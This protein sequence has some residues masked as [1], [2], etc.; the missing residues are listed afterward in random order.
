MTPHRL[1]A[2]WL[3]TFQSE[4]CADRLAEGRTELPDVVY[5]YIPRGHVD[6]GAPNSLRATQILALNDDMECNVTTMHDREMDI[7]DF[8]ALVQSRLKECLEIEVSEEELIK[9]SL[10][11]S[12]VRLS[13]FVQEY[14]IGWEWSH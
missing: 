7:L 11:H 9:R 6:K 3:R 8:L 10:R 2:H 4:E 5:K 13:T 12:D 1:T 14:L